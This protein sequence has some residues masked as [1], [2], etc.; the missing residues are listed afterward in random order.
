MYVKISP[1][2]PYIVIGK[3]FLSNFFDLYIV[4]SSLSH[5][6]QDPSP[7]SKLLRFSLTPIRDIE[8]LTGVNFFPD[9][10]PQQQNT[11]ELRLNN[12]LWTTP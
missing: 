8:R 3:I 5:Q 7:L 9:L 4:Q 11:L 1:I 10:T 2:C 12:K 6:P